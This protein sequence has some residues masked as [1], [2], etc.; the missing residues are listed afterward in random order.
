MIAI[1]DYG[2]GNICSVRNALA[3]AG[4]AE[5]LYTSDKDVLA[6]ADKV[7]LPGVGDAA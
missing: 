3:R 6:A 1:V 5:P 4:I 7:I 2:V